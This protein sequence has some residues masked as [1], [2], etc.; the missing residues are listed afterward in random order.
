MKLDEIT[1]KKGGYALKSSGVTRVKKADIA[2]TIKHASKLSRVPTKDLHKIGS[3]GKT[4]TSGDIDL[5]VD[6]NE[7]DPMTIHNRMITKLGEDKCTYNRGTKVASYAIP[8]R[9]DKKNGFVQVDFMYTTNPEWAKFSYFSAGENSKYKG[10]VRAILL[11]SIAASIQ[12]PGTD[13]FEY[14]PDTQDLIIRAGRTVDLGQGL[15]RIFQHRGKKK[16]GSGYLKSMKSIDI[17]KF[18][19]MFPDVEIK[20]GQVIID[21][22]QKVLTILFGSGVKPSDVESAEQI[23]Q[24]I[25]KKFDDEKQATIFKKATDR[26]RSVRDKMRLPPEMSKID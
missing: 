7:Y 6:V 23:I 10:A 14:D 1:P 20:G 11:T 13:H 3:T 5:A 17:D 25:K 12:E 19:E 26:A 15:R 9:G 24:L 2:A 18:K 4:E 21:D 16:D 22:P 8:I